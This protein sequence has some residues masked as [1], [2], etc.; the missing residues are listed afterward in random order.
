[1]RLNLHVEAA[2][3]L[4]QAQQ[5]LSEGD[6]LQGFVENRFADGAHGRLEFIDPG[7]RRHPTRFH[8]QGGN[9][10]IVALEE[11]DEILGQV[12]L[13]AGLQGA[14]D[15]EIDRRVARVLGILGLHENISRMHV[16]MEKIVPK[17]LGKENLDAVLGKLRYI[18]AAGAQFRQLTDDNAMDALH[19]HDVGATIVPI[20]F[21]HIEQ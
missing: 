2:G 18:R 16:G 21:G 3:G 9:S 5:N 11:R 12:M 10:C 8:M 13:V 4:E 20:D 7:S 14:D 1:M 6:F 15:A 19:D 17:D